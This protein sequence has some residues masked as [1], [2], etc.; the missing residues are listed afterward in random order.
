MV[1]PAAMREHPR[2]AGKSVMEGKF[3][4]PDMRESTTRRGT[5]VGR[6]TPTT[7]VSK[8]SPG[9]TG[10]A[11]RDIAAGTGAG[12]RSGRAGDTQLREGGE[13]P[14]QSKGLLTQQNPGGV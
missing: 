4:T 9:G 14:A 2:L 1:K 3:A 13:P 6:G 7:T 11:T 8:L 12:Q 10:T 5:E